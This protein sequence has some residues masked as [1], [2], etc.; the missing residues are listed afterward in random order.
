ML[1]FAWNVPLVSLVFLKRS[2]VSHS[3]VFLYFFALITEEGFL[4]SPYYSLELCIQMGRSFLFS[5][6]F[7]S[8]LFSAICKASSDNHFPFLH[9]FSLGIVWITTYCTMWQTSVHSSSGVLSLRS[10]PWNLFVNST[11]CITIRDLIYVIRESSCGFPYFLQFKSEF[12]NKEFMMWGTV[13]SQS[14]FCWLYRVSPPLGGGGQALF[15][16]QKRTSENAPQ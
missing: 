8:L 10:N 7:A 3:I 9:F 5:F 12:C 13:S 6:A 15:F 11:V 2:L 14:C 4:I 1:I 16:I